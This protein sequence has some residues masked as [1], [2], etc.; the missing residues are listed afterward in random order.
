MKEKERYMG[1]IGT[2]QYTQYL[3]YVLYFLKMVNSCKQFTSYQDIQ[4]L[5]VINHK[6][7]SNTIVHLGTPMAMVLYPSADEVTLQS[8]Q[9]YKGKVQ[10]SWHF[11]QRG[12]GQSIW[13]KNLL[14]SQSKMY[15]LYTYTYIVDR[16]IDR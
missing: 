16:L 3:K 9:S 4:E 14:S 13:L 8:V 7:K 11:L 1:K 10:F 5:C 2:L 12:N 15:Q 6:G